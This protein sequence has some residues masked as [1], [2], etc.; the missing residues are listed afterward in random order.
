M[1][2]PVGADF[3]GHGIGYKYVAPLGNHQRLS[4]LNALKREG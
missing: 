2:R 1:S 4:E 3:M